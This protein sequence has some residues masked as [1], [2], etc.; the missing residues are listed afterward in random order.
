[1]APYAGPLA[2][3]LRVNTAISPFEFTAT[4]EASPRFMSAGSFRKFGAESNGI[5]GTDCCANA[6]PA[7]ASDAMSAKLVR[8]IDPP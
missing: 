5:S 6:V 4:P 3:L 7:N 2:L 1:M 8:L